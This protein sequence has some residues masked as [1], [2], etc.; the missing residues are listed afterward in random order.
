MT[1]TQRTIL[2]GLAK[3]PEGEGILLDR[4]FKRPAA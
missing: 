1:Y 4:R 3:C 2:V